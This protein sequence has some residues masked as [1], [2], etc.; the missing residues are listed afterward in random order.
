AEGAPPPAP[1]PPPP[2]PPPRP[3]PHAGAGVHAGGDLDV[4]IPRGLDPAAATTAG[5]GSPLDVAGPAAL[6]AGLVQLQRHRLAR[7]LE[8]L[9]QRQLDARLDVAPAPTSRT[10]AAAQVPQIRELELGG[11]ATAGAGAGEAARIAEDRAEEIREASRV[12]LLGEAH[13]APLERRAAARTRP[14]AGAG[15]RVTLPVGS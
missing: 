14:R 3:P 13:V 1:T 5:A 7:A 2:P 15:L 8:G 12:A 11:S 9:L 4:E 10:E 6:R